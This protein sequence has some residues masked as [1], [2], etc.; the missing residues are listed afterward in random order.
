MHLVFLYGI[1]IKVF[2]PILRKKPRLSHVVFPLLVF[3]IWFYSLLTGMS[4]SITRAATMTTFV[5]LSEWLGRRVDKT[6][7]M[8]ASLILLCCLEPQ[9]LLSAGFQLSFLA[10]CGIFYLHPVILS[11]IEPENRLMRQIWEMTS[12]TLAAQIATFP[13]SLYL[14]GQFP[15]WFLMANMVIVPVS[16]LVMYA[17]MVLVMLGNIPWIG[18]WLGEITS[19]SIQFLRYLVELISSLPFAVTDNIYFP[20]LMVVSTYATILILFYFFNSNTYYS[21]VA[22]LLTLIFCL[23]SIL[24]SETDFAKEDSCWMTKSKSGPILINQRGNIAEIIAFSGVSGMELK[25]IEGTLATKRNVR[26]FKKTIINQKT[27]IWLKRYQT[28]CIHLFPY[29]WNLNSENLKSLENTRI[30]IMET[31]PYEGL[32]DRIDKSM[33]HLKKMVLLKRSY[34]SEKS[35]AKAKSLG[36]QICSLD[37]IGYVRL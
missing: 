7:L 4:P 17:G 6:N 27:N 24:K 22:C 2:N 14:F 1:L 33:P 3:T 34:L 26:L 20:A 31:K 35:L 32:W 9:M 19:I 36:I 12:V 37:E 11:S 29:N 5:I 28:T 23:A 30:L 16:T 8:C 13:L 10:V 21:L 15:N 25:R 18:E